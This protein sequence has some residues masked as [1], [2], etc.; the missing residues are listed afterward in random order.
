MAPGHAVGCGQWVAF[1]TKVY[2]SRVTN[3][4][5]SNDRGDRDRRVLVATFVC[6]GRANRRPKNVYAHRRGH[7]GRRIETGR[8]GFVKREVGGGLYTTARLQ[9]ED[10]RFQPIHVCGM[11]GRKVE[12]AEGLDGRNL[13]LADPGLRHEAVRGVDHQNRAVWLVNLRDVRGETA[14]AFSPTEWP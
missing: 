12:R 1:V 9:V 10:I 14:T 7:I 5:R 2:P 11:R 8:D 4:G 3:A 6:R 13:G